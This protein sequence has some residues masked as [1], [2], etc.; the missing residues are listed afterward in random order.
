M[1]A[2]KIGNKIVRATHPCYLTAG[3][4][5][6]HNGEIDVA[7]W[8]FDI[9]IDAGCDAVKSH[10]R[11]VNVV[12]TAKELAISRENPFDASNGALRASD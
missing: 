2:V 4:G 9:A 10:K 6:N 11:T 3:I 1:S 5:I 7:K 8:F 12:Y